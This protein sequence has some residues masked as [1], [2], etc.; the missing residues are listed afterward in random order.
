[1]LW[2]KRRRHEPL[3]RTGE[4]HSGRALDQPGLRAGLGEAASPA[5]VTYLA[6]CQQRPVALRRRLHRLRRRAARRQMGQR[7]RDG[8]RSEIG[9]LGVDAVLPAVQSQFVGPG[10]GRGGGWSFRQ[11]GSC[12]KSRRATEKQRDTICGRR[13]RRAGELAEDL[14]D[15][16]RKRHPVQR[17]RVRVLSATL[18]GHP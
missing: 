16:A 10:D 9:P 13:S 15:L 11:S 5:A 6:L 3:R 7:A 17:K 12:P 1:M 4:T 18:P 14:D 8:S 2:R